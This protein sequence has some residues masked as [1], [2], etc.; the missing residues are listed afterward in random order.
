MTKAEY[1]DQLNHK[2][3]VMPNTERQDALEYYDG[4]LSDAE[5]EAAAMA[6]LGS[7]GEV[8]ASI[9]VSHAAREAEP[10]EANQSARK[11]G[12]K[13]LRAAW[14]VALVIFALPV[15]LPLVMVLAALAFSLTLSIVI[16]AGVSVLGFLFGG[17]VSIGFFLMVIL[18]DAGTA[19][20]F[21]GNGLMSLGLGILLIKLTAVLMKGFPMIARF[22]EKK[23][24]NKIAGR[25]RYG[26]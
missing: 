18:Q 8:A 23:I 14:M 2:L 24:G 11:A 26:K 13:G 22:V 7:P 3:R 17:V 6:R 1:L 4:Y 20:L 19:L 25:N 5:D 10:G 21:L 15:G 16:A 12:V 9:L